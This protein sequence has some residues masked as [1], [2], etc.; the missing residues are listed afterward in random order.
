MSVFIIAEAGVNHNGSIEMAKQL[1]DAAQESGVDAIKFQ[2][3]QAQQLVV[4][5]A[6]KA[7]YQKAQTGNEESQ[8][9]MLEKLQLSFNQQQELFDYCQQKKI[10][11]LSSPFDLASAEF[12]IHQLGLTTI[13]LGSGELTNAELLYCIGKN[14]CDLILSTGMSDLEEIRQTLSVLAFAYLQPDGL[15][16]NQ[17]HF[18]QVIQSPQAQQVLIQKVKLL[19]C[20]TEYPCPYHEVNLNN[21][22]TIR[23]Q[24]NLPTGFSDHTQGIHVSLAAVAMGATIIEKHFTLD[25][26]LP[27]PDHRASIMPNELKQLVNQTREIE[28]ALG[29]AEKKVTTVEQQNRPIVRKGLYAQ[30]TIVKGEL[31]S[32]EN[33]SVKRPETDLSAQYYWDLV[34]QPA[35]ANYHPNEPID[36]DNLD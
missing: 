14:Q 28:S 18:R 6:P 25:R 8:L 30:K 32:P 26:Q 5:E 20:T 11:F 1:V 4:E 36:K 27:G 3:F 7:A 13:K 24:F 34:G 29:S 12:L 35:K 33:L 19:H 9:Q 17:K 2:S 21:I 23:E 10:H 22:R 15:L 16:P 31:F